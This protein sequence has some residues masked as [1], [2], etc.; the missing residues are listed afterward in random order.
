L[1][2]AF[3]KKWWAESDFKVPQGSVFGPIL[4]VVFIN[5]LPNSVVCD[6]FMLADDTKI[7]R[8]IS[9]ESDI[10]IIQKDLDELFNWSKLW[11]LKFHPDKKF[12][13]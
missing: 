1:V 13:H 7:F 4:F 2:Q 12:Y 9:D 11:L 8:T 5:D 3:L 6:A 10:D